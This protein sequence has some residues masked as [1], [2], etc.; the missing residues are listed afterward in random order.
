MTNY[1]FIRH[2]YILPILLVFGCYITDST[3]SEELESKSQK[4]QENI[5]L[6]GEDLNNNSNE[7]I[8]LQEKIAILEL[9]VN[10]NSKFIKE[11]KDSLQAFRQLDISVETSDQDIINSLIR[12]QSKLNIIEDK[13]F[14]SDSLYFNL[15][16]DFVLIESQIEN[17]DSNIK[18]IAKLNDSIVKVGTQDE[19]TQINDEVELEN[20]SNRNEITNYKS[21]YDLAVDLYKE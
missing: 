9:E 8:L 18:S 10:S 13:I 21:S 3:A 12:I 15:L 1:S 14:Y 4:N 5:G 7:I 19:N 2:K 16:N 11:L 17:L 6:L 20:E